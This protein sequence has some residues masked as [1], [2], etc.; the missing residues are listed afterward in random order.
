MEEYTDSLNDGTIYK[1]DLVS[2][3]KIFHSLKNFEPSIISK[4]GGG[5]LSITASTGAGKTV[6]IKDLLK[7][8]E[9]YFKEV[10]LISRTAKMQSFYDF[11]PR[12]NI[13]DKFSEEFLLNLIYSRKSRKEANNKIAL[14]PVLLIFD[15]IINDINYKKSS[16]MD[17]LFTE[18]RQYNITVFFLTQNFTSLKVLQRNNVRIAIS[19][20]HDTSKERRKFSESYLSLQ[21]DRIGRMLFDKVTKEKPYQCIVVEVFKNGASAKEKIKK[22]IADPNVKDPKIKPLVNRYEVLDLV[23]IRKTVISVHDYL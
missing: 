4:L 23:P 8:N 15:D 12:E 11:I 10:H 9:N 18:G 7:H 20:N 1:N 2:A 14:E 3:D 19:F 6:L 17:N 16:A 5:C 21:N 22:Y 13:Q